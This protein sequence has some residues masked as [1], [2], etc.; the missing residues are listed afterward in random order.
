MHLADLSSGNNE[1]W[2]FSH[3]LPTDTSEEQSC[4]QRWQAGT[5]RKDDGESS[6]SE[7]TGDQWCPS[8][9]R[10]WPHRSSHMT[11]RAGQHSGR[12]GAG[13]AEATTAPLLSAAKA[14][15]R[16]PTRSPFLPKPASKHFQTC[17]RL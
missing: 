2:V 8:P 17:V 6:P 10:C 14:A 3:P 7:N 9:G 11:A 5:G 4:R 16:P 15:P 13:P 12:D 1:V